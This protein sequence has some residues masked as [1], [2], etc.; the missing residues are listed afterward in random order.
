MPSK[1]LSKFRH[2]TSP[3]WLRDG[4]CACTQQLQSVPSLLTSFE[5]LLE[6]LS[7]VFSDS[8]QQLRAPRLG[9]GKTWTLES[10]TMLQEPIKL[11]QAYAGRSHAAGAIGRSGTAEEAAAQAAICAWRCKHGLHGSAA[12]SNAQAAQAW[13]SALHLHV[14]PADVYGLPLCMH[15]P[16]CR[17]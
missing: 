9:E 11:P 2:S 13:T 17:D 7:G 1:N 10:Y 3:I 12:N 8:E 15:L 16:P 14:L 4:L 5:T 6:A